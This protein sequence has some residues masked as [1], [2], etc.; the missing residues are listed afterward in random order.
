MS[1]SSFLVLKSYFA[2]NEFG[3]FKLQIFMFIMSS[4][5]FG[6]LAPLALIANLLLIDLFS[7]LL[8]FGFA[9]IFIGKLNFSK[10]FLDMQNNFL[11]LIEKFSDFEF[12]YLIVQLSGSAVYTASRSLFIFLSGILVLNALRELSIRRFDSFEKD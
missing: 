9:A 3:K 5:I 11:V 10:F 4:A 7:V 8:V 2:R 12:D 1:W 6:E